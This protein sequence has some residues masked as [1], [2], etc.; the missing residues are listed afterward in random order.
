VTLFSSAYPLA[1]LC[2]LL[3]NLIEVRSDAF[4]LC[5][6][7]QR[8]FPQRVGNIGSWQTAMEVMGVI[9]INSKK[10]V[11]YDSWSRFAHSPSRILNHLKIEGA[12][13]ASG[14][15]VH[16]LIKNQI[17]FSSYIRKFR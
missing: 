4:K 3:N 10:D 1:G 5:F 9:G 12:G 7:Y 11:L 16:A 17:K 8:P 14:V 2:A 15:K 6:I 13:A